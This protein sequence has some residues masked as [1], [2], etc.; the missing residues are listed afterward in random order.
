MKIQNA[1][2][3][4]INSFKGR[5]K[6]GFYCDIPHCFFQVYWDLKTEKVS[7]SDSKETE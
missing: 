2:M 7:T 3:I 4:H 1:A 6:N 5:Q